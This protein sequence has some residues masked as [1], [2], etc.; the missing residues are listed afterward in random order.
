MRLAS[1]PGRLFCFKLLQGLKTD[2][3]LTVTLQYLWKSLWLKWICETQREA[4]SPPR[5]LL[6]LGYL[7]G[8]L[9]GGGW[10]LLKACECKIEIVRNQ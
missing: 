10:A 4:G 6:H 8:R 3:S 2:R 1:V 7:W 9:N 5:D